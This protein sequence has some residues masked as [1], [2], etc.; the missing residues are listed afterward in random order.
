LDY[1]SAGA[2]ARVSYRTFDGKQSDKENEE[3]TLKLLSQ[4]PKHLSPLEHVM[5]AVK[6]GDNYKKLGRQC[7]SGCWATLRTL[8]N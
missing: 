8:F 2:C 6:G 4:E 5:E 1:A 7:V 3:L